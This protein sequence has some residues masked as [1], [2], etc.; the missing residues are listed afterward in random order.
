MTD[1]LDDSVAF[2]DPPSIWFVLPSLDTPDRNSLIPADLIVCILV[3]ITLC[4][5]LWPAKKQKEK[6]IK[7]SL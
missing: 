2:P 6:P 4:P 7:K 5:L 3:R 1:Q